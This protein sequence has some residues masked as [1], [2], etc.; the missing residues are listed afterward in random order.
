MNFHL[1]EEE[2]AKN[3]IF[4]PWHVSLKIPRMFPVVSV[5]KLPEVSVELGRSAK[6]N[7][8]SEAANTSWHFE[9]IE[10]KKIDNLKKTYRK[11]VLS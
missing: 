8:S 10:W 9:K 4:K 11:V 5:L 7:H 6:I 2:A 1:G 3:N